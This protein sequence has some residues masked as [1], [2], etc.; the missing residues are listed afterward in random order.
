M[1]YRGPGDASLHRTQVQCTA[2]L[3]RA[4]VLAEDVAAQVLDATQAAVA[5]NP[6]TT[7][8][9]W[10]IEK[11]A[12]KEMCFSFIGKNPEL[13]AL[14]PDRLFAAWNDRVAAGQTPKI[15]YSQNKGWQVRSREPGDAT[16]A[17]NTGN[18]GDYTDDAGDTGYGSGSESPPADDPAQTQ[19]TKLS[20]NYYDSTEIKPQRWLVK[21]LLPETGV[22]ILSGQWG[23]FKTTAALDLSVAVMTGQA[24]AGQYRIKR[25]GAVLYIAPEG[26][27]TLQSRLAAIA[28]HRGAG[29]KLPFA[30]RGDCPLLTDKTAGLTIAR[31]VAEAATHF[32]Q[33]YGLPIALVWV[34]TYMAAAGLNSSGDDNDVAATQKAFNTLRLVSDQCRAFVMTVDHHGKVVEAGTRGSSGKE[35]NADTVLVT[36]AEREI[37][38]AVAKTRMAAR[39]QRDGICGFEVPFTPEAVELGLDEDG[40]PITAIV[41][42]WGKQQRE[43]RCRASVNPKTLTCFAR[44]SPKP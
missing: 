10:S 25:P 43:R 23:S 28:R 15:V 7:R 41:L 14:L 16:P 34:D 31:Y 38:G 37:T 20:W 18:G 5:N 12:I 26:A 39:K 2:A 21:Q 13:A 29:A 4:G 27:G 19:S 42:D 3:L 32:E 1:Q 22:G 33:V 30:W 9:N 40:D 11:H 6:D 36:L 8:W 35:G 17:G 44:C 24:F